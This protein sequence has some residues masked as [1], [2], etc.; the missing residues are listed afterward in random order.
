M[1]RVRRD[2]VYSGEMGEEVKLGSL[3]IVERGGI[4]DKIVERGR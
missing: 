2:G 1:C 4:G 3:C